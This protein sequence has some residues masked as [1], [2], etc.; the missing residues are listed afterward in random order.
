MG[1]DPVQNDTDALDV[2]G[3]D[4]VLELI[5]R[6]IATRRDEVAKQLV[7]P[8]LVER[9]LENQYQFNVCIAENLEVWD[10]HVGQFYVAE[11]PIILFWAARHDPGCTS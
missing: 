1:R 8:G 6:S 2:L 4:E 9:V 10:K 7:A 3:I 11:R 5:R